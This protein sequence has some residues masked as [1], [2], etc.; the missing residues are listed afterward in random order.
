MPQNNLAINDPLIGA[1]KIW[2]A[3]FVI[4]LSY[5]NFFTE[6]LEEISIGVKCYEQIED[7]LRAQTVQQGIT[8]DIQ[9]TPGEVKA[10]Y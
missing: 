10:Y 2:V 1:P 3:E 8:K 9:V 6:S 5:A 4:P 7:K